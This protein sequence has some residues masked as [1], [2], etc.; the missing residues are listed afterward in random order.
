MLTSFLRPDPR[1]DSRFER[2]L[3]IKIGNGVRAV[4]EA[5]SPWEIPGKSNADATES[6]SGI[7][8]QASKA[9]ILLFSQPSTYMFDWS[10]MHRGQDRT[11]VIAP[12]FVKRLDESGKPLP[13]T[14]VL[15]E[16]RQ[17]KA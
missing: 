4:T 6:L 11:I 14:Q 12:A 3:D 8:H 1:T 17:A 15:I 5:F 16:A 13:F 7:L 2:D 10:S 9:G